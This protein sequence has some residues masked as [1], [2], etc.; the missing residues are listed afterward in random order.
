VL[1]ELRDLNDAERIEYFRGVQPIWGGGLPEDRFIAFQR[2]LAD[3]K[4][5]GQ[6]YR[7]FGLFDGPRLL[8][9]LKAYDL[10]GACAG[11]PLRVLGIGA[12]FTP[13]ALRRHGHAH[14]M[15]EL[16]LAAHAARGYDAALLFSDIGAEYYER[17]GFRALA[18]EEC[19]AEAPDLPRGR[20]ARAAA[21]GEETELSRVF[22]R[23]RAAT[24]ALCLERDGWVVRFQL[25]RL[26]ELARARG[27]GEPEWGITARDGEEEAA[28]MVRLTR[29][30]VDV[31]DAAWPS[32]GARDH[33][34]SGL[35]D[36]LLRSGRLRIRFWPS[37]QLRGL[38]PAQPRTNAVAMVA[39]LRPG[40][41]LPQQ[42]ARAEL[43][44]IDHI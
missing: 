28:A 3:S 22:A 21:P 12:V 14:R 44:L 19:A 5:A 1:E 34:L 18:S 38:V 43:A 8:S 35:R 13:P 37:H 23:G 39:Q 32:E 27:S 2:R 4:E 30:S 15:L 25:R 36:L 33:L 9:A 6:R 41:A 40:A 42:G 7:L 11:A 29:D 16:V 24:G 20:A 31:L 17:L 10:R 26:R